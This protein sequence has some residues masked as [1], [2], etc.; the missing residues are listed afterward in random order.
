MMNE[1][2][3]VIF[4][5]IAQKFNANKNPMKNTLVLGWKTNRVYSRNGGDPSHM[6]THRPIEIQKK[7][8]QFRVASINETKL[9]KYHIQMTHFHRMPD[10]INEQSH[11]LWI[12]TS[13]PD[14]TY[15]Y[16]SQNALDF[17][18]SFKFINRSFIFHFSGQ[19]NYQWQRSRN[20]PPWE[21]HSKNQLV[22]SISALFIWHG[23]I[24]FVR[25]NWTP[26]SSPGE[27]LI[28]SIQFLIYLLASVGAIFGLCLGASIIS[29]IEVI[30]FVAIHVF[31]RTIFNVMRQ[32]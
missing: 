28:L 2:T 1:C 24:S 20:W 9:K 18:G 13:L 6:F 23:T 4:S 3:V 5:H 16:M 10:E 14:P 15:S 7:A 26:A 32:H 25:I 12:S 17:C 30:Y 27:W 19:A 21:L 29:I 11:F 8:Q 31:D 22:L